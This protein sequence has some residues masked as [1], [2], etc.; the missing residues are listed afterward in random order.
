M[1]TIVLPGCK[2]SVVG[3]SSLTR[4]LHVHWILWVWLLI[5][6]QNTGQMCW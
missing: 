2:L 4:C 5:L 3:R 6:F 1:L